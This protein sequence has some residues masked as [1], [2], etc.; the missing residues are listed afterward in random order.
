M[1]A[2]N[3]IIT[4]GTSGIGFE[5]ASTLAK[6]GDNLLLVYLSD[7]P[8]AQAALNELQ[9][10]NPSI[11]IFCEKFNLSTN[12]GITNFIKFAN[13]TFNGKIDHLISCHGRV[14]PGLFINKSATEI[15]A[16][17]TEHLLSNVLITHA[18][19]ESM[20]KNRYGRI[21]YLTSMTSSKIRQGMSDYSI[22]KH[23]L[24]SLAQN[25]ASEYFKY[26]ITLNCIRSGM[27]ETPLTTNYINNFNENTD[28]SIV[29]KTII[30]NLVELITSDPSCSFNGSTIPVDGG[31]F[32]CNR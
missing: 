26:N 5:I 32:V 13:K 28:G 1:D 18:V 21:I 6:R 31:Q 14:S 4:G 30:A 22:S 7:D 24:E 10:L 19:L 25:L 15:L 11:K 20:I 17:M 23:A 9:T 16:T 2:K 8:K 27:A 3:T 29:S 12:D